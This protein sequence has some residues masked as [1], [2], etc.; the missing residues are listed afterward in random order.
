MSN[1]PFNTG[2][3]NPFESPAESKAPQGARPASRPTSA[4]VFG[5]LNIAMGVLGICGIG[6]A[7]VQ[8][9]IPPE[10][11]QPQGAD[12][13]PVFTIMERSP[14]LRIFQAVSMI[15]GTV[16][17][18]MLIVAGINLLGDKRSGRVLSV[19]YSVITI[20]TTIL[21]TV[22]NIFLLTMPL[23]EMAES[24]PE[25]PE[26]IAAVAGGIGGS[27]GGCFGIIYPVLLLIFMKREAVVN[28]YNNTGK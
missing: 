21:G 4:T 22:G 5:A 11:M 3:T 25:G 19:Y 20:F 9:L 15:I 28:Y 10:M 27:V 24:M 14:A 16:T 6:A 1:D 7:A 26:K 17:T 18:V 8:M 12:P 23:M 13:N 2:G